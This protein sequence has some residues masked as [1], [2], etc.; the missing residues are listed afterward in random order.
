MKGNQNL[1]NK[2]VT[3]NN[4][5]VNSLPFSLR[6]R[7]NSREHRNHSRQEAQTSSHKIIE[8]P[9]MG[10]AILNHQVETVQH[11]Q[12]Q[13]YKQTL[14]IILDH[15]HLIIIGTE[16]DHDDHFH[17]INLVMSGITLIHC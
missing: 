11:T 17:E 2:Q 15:N 12:G 5:I 4:I 7:S 10:T 9:I 13:I 1:P 3:S 6:S 8:N 16:I 14:N